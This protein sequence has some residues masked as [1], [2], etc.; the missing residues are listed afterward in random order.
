MVKVMEKPIAMDDLGVPPF[1]ETPIYTKLPR[2]CSSCLSP[3]TNIFALISETRKA[4][5]PAMQQN[6]IPEFLWVQDTGNI[7]SVSILT[8]TYVE[9]WNET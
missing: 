8:K 9:S 4:S 5:V 6:S 2:C 3:K 1:K 7:C